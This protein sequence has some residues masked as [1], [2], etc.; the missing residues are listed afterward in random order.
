MTLTDAQRLKFLL[1]AHGVSISPTTRRV[2]QEASGGQPLSSDDF[3][4]TSGVILRLE[5]NVW[6][7]VPIAEFNPNFVAESPYALECADDGLAIRGGGFECKAEYWPQPSFHSASGSDGQPLTNYVVTHGDR[8]RL[9]PVHGCGMTCTFCDVPY[10]MRYE[11]KAVARMVEAVS[12]ALADPLQ[13]ARHLLISGGTPRASDIDWLKDV[14]R[15]ILTEFSSIDIDI[16]M[17]P[18]QNLLDVD[19]LHAL[20]VH[21]LSINLELFSDNAARR[22][23]PQKYRQGQS[24]YLEFIERATSTLGLG[25]VR[26]MLMVGLEPPEETLLGVRAILERGGVPVLSP[27]R[28]DPSTP[29]RAMVPPSASLLEDVFLKSSE[30]ASDMGGKLGPSC[31]PCSHNTLTLAEDLSCSTGNPRTLSRFGG[32]WHDAAP[33]ADH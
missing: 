29:L 20:G 4:S 6:V 23:M 12:R 11:T 16:M 25:R 9:S 32:N 8:A 30:I 18:T 2:L 28:P 1:F 19:E 10:G 14:Y 24:H 33:P 31:V 13:P 5:D 26:S 15:T 17:V 21:Q 3:A 27:F 7:N 22:Y